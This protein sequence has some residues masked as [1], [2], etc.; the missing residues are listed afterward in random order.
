M[1]AWPESG[2]EASCWVVSWRRYRKKEIEKPKLTLS[3]PGGIS[4][5]SARYGFA[6]DHVENFQ[7]V[8]STG[9]IVNANQFENT[10]LWKSL[11]GG[12]NNLAIVTAMTLKTH[13]QGSF[14]GGQ[15]FH[16]IE[17]R[18]EIFGALE[19]LIHDYDPYA[20]FITTLVIEGT[21]RKWFVGSGYHYTK[22]DP[23]IPLADQPT[24]FQSMLSIKRTPVFPGTPDNTLRI[25]NLTNYS[26]EYAALLS[27]RKRWTFASI[28]FGNSAQMMEEF[29][30]MTHA[31][32]KPFLG[33]QTFQ[34][35]LSYQPM[36]TMITERSGAV[37]MLGPIQTQ[38]N[39]FNIHFALGV[40][41]EEADR[42]PIIEHA[43]RQLFAS[44]EARAAELKVQ[45]DFI[46]LTYADHW[47]D[48]IG[49]RSE[50]TVAE[51]RSTAR[52][53]DPSA[54]FQRQV[55]GGF[56]LPAKGVPFM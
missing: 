1:G 42:D 33:M 21:M 22:S 9:D 45:R 14:W 7:A 46:P 52:R 4:Y 36:P 12:S 56:K 53:Y 34:L 32:V 49:R 25:D 10:D 6:C 5:L 24:P 38:G 30:Q 44:A 13:A 31:A 11:R 54:M 15:T 51:L 29:F 40:G 23:P 50:F 41:D 16:G 48:P 35:S 17:Q 28:S 20:H 37:D 39:M 43:I 55:P 19:D 27:A 47:Q 26:R 8:L 2:L 3:I 18:G